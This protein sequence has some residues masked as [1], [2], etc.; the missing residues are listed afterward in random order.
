MAW[1]SKKDNDTIVQSAVE[2]HAVLRELM[3]MEKLYN[4]FVIS[5][6]TIKQR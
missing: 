6:E 2:V 4:Y 5:K 3:E 1:Y